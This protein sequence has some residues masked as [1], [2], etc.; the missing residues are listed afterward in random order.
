MPADKIDLVVVGV[1]KGAHGVCGD[2]RIKSFTEVPEDVFS[3][4]ALMSETGEVL[5]ETKKYRTA[6]DHFIVSP[7][8]THQK[9]EWDALKGTKLHAARDVLP[10]AAED[11]FY[12]EDL[13]GLWVYDA[14]GKRIGQVKAALNFGA[15][16][17]LEVKLGASNDVVI[18]P[19]TA[20]D[21]PEISLA[22]RKLTLTTLDIWTNQEN[23]NT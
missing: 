10:P 8:K 6:K 9:E 19:F 5:V 18:I 22:E 14:D 21:F 11:E 17:I 16:D 2:V 15:G 12:I 23:V 20:E 1:I 4:G 7:A 13:V 3:F